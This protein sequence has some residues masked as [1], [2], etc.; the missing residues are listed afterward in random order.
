[1]D[2]AMKPQIVEEYHAQDLGAPFKVV[3]INSV[4]QLVD[5]DTGEV[6]QVI[7][8]NLRGL[9]KCIAITRI[10]NPRKLSGSEIKFVR[11]AVKLSAK[12]VAKMIDVS[13]EHLS[14]CEAG[15]KILSPSAEKCLRVSIFLEQFKMLD[16]IDALALEDKDLLDKVKKVRTAIRAISAIVEEMEISSAFD[17]EPLEFRFKIVSAIEANLFDDE[18]NADWSSNDDCLEMAA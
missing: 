4:K 9:I 10:L 7:I 13:P 16:D 6:E 1:M 17:P 5:E 2:T 14:R 8:P 11:K 15:S 3:L 12:H 18:P